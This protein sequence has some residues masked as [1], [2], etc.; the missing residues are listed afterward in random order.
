MCKYCDVIDGIEESEV[1]VSGG[2]RSPEYQRICEAI[3]DIV[4]MHYSDPKTNMFHAEKFM[5]YAVAPT[6]A[7]LK[8]NDQF[9]F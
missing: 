8:K 9:I 5:E 4:M 3:S 7:Q 6:K 2:K 1:F